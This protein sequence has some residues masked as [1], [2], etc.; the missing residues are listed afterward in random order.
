MAGKGSV[1]GMGHS[2]TGGSKDFCLPQPPHHPERESEQWWAALE[3]REG[4]QHRADCSG[5][6]VCHRHAGKTRQSWLPLLPE[7]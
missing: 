1:V 3:A 4:S 5:K 2:V 6:H 7:R